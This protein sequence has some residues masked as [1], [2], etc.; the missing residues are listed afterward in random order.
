MLG[1]S[2]AGAE[3]PEPWENDSLL[4]CAL[5]ALSYRAWLPILD[6]HLSQELYQAWGPFLGRRLPSGKSL[7]PYMILVI[8]SGWVHR[9]SSPTFNT[10]QDS[11]RIIR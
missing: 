9:T 11:H 1:L 2:R 10:T 7:H 5:G 8:L 6:K 4:P 3:L